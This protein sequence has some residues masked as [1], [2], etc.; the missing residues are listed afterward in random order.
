LN[1]SEGRDQNMITTLEKHKNII[2]VY[3]HT[4]TFYDSINI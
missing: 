1:S 3:V 4:H 2:I